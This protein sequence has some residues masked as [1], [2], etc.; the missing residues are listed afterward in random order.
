MRELENLIKRT[1]ILG[2][3]ESIRRELAD[4]I[5]GR[6]LRS[7]PIPVLQSRQ[8]AGA[9]GRGAPPPAVAAA[10]GRRRRRGAGAADRI[11]EGHR[12]PGGARSGDGS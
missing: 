4:A 12:A 5:A 3:D 10:A 8:A 6:T 7:G 2:T 1:V 11:A 9:A